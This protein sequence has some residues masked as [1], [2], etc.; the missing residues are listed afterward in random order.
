MSGKQSAIVANFNNYFEAEEA[1]KEIRKAGFE[2]N[3]HR[4]QGLSFG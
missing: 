2:K 4:R 3:V 1:V